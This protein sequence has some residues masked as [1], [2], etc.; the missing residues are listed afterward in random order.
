MNNKLVFDD[1]HTFHI[2]YM[3][4]FLISRK[5]C[6]SVQ[7]QGRVQRLTFEYIT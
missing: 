1:S 2:E 4:M 6:S 5:M 3:S 7:G